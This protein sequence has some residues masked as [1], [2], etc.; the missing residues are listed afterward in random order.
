ME[1]LQRLVRFAAVAIIKLSIGVAALN[2]GETTNLAIATNSIVSSELQ[3]HVE[4]L[5]DDSF[6]GREAGSRGG[7]A[8]GNYLLSYYEN[9]GI[10]GAGD[11]GGFFQGF[12]AGY[13]N[14]L[15]MIEGSDP[16][17][18]NEVIVIGA[19][20]DHVGYGNRRNSYGPTGYIHNGADDN[21]SG[22]SGLIEMIEAFKMMP[23]PPRRTILFA[24]WD[25]EEQGLLGSEYWV[26][27]PT[28]ELSRVKLMINAD[29][30]GRLT[31]K[32]LEVYGTRSGGGLRRLVANNNR[33]GVRIAYNWKMRADSDHYPFFQK[34]I[35]VLLF[36]TGLHDNYHRPS[37]DAHLINTK[38]LEDISRLVFHVAYAAAEEDV[39]PTFR[40]MAGSD[41]ESTQR[42]FEQP[43]NPLQ[44]RFG[45]SLADQADGSVMITSVRR[46]TPA[47]MAGL[48][49]GDRITMF[50]S[51]LVSSAEQVIQSTWQAQGEVPIQIM[52]SGVPGPLDLIATFTGKRWRIGVS[53]RQD[54]A[55]PTVYLVTQV[56]EGSP[57]EAAGIRVKD[58]IY[59]VNGLAVPTTD[60]LL[61][62]LGA[63]AGPFDV[64]I[65]REGNIQQVV[66]AP[67]P[68]V[69]L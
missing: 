24:H 45:A 16:V 9:N 11:R 19:H 67:G 46:G 20:Y 47:S 7:R 13:R 63:E 52:R 10:I 51:V 21:A 44:P 28:V 36:H 8:A 22:T 26:A 39:L 31:E 43:Q 41:S 48:R 4:T 65:E 62:M 66:L 15:G 27:H 23:T 30:I 3:R 56:A 34:Q 6:E 54:Q 17:L 2:G 57:A 18:K 32:G 49:Q 38:G 40:S 61:Q 14:I 53:W 58:R 64:V 37:D 1:Q 33:Q 55:D 35:P 25:G 5:A 50:Q 12:N 59:S 68:P 29:M 42:A 60:A 69:S